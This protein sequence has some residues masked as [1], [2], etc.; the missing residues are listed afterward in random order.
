[1]VFVNDRRTWNF[2]GIRITNGARRTSEIKSRIAT[3][4]AAFKEKMRLVNG[5]LY[6]HLWQE[7]IQYVWS[8][9]CQVLKL[10]RFGKQIKNMWKVWKCG[11]G[12]GWRRSIGAI[13]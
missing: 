8:I 5:E 3:A 11:V 12:E 6:L 4:K 13:V 1:V 10:G 2:F 9:A 7:L